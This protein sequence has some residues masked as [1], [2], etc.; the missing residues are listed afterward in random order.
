[1]NLIV[2]NCKFFFFQ[3]IKFT[4]ENVRKVMAKNKIFGTEKYLKILLYL[5]K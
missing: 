1:M 2:R 3:I 5:C 4:L